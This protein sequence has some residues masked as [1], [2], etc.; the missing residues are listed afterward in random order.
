MTD[1]PRCPEPFDNEP[2]LAR[3]RRS[4]PKEVVEERCRIA[5]QLVH[6]QPGVVRAT[7]HS[8]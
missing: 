8:G 6:Q 7:T 4:Q 1:D 2:V 5:W 3:G